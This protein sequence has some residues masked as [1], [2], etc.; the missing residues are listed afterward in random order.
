MSEILR[1]GGCAEGG[2]DCGGCCCDI[3]MLSVRD[4]RGLE[5]D[6]DE[7]KGGAC[8]RRVF[9]GR[10][11]RG[12]DVM[13]G[14]AVEGPD[15]EVDGGVDAE[16]GDADVE[17]GCHTRES[18][19]HQNNYRK[20]ASPNSGMKDREKEFA[21]EYVKRWWG[22]VERIVKNKLRSWEVTKK[23]RN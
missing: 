11:R 3:R 10:G 5:V 18:P 6:D 12:E 22:W 23:T 1:C 7:V 20:S 17:A 15:E 19:P 13:V 8:E 9:C 4:C 21:H 2:R 14:E 16:E